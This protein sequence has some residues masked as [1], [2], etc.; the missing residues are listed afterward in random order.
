MTIAVAAS[1]FIWLPLS[2]ALS[3]RIGRKPILLAFSVLALLTA[4]PAL[5]WLVRE[6]L[7]RSLT[8][9]GLKDESDLALAGGRFRIVRRQRRHRFSRQRLAPFARI[10]RIEFAELP[11]TISGKIRRVELRAMEKERHAASVRGEHEYW[12]DDFIDFD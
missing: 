2:G 6:A 5:A 3:D 4:Y 11:K 9:V 10:R 8:G 12:E 7:R 1:N